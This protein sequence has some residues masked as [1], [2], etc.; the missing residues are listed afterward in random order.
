[1]RSV[2]SIAISLCYVGGGRFDAMLTGRASRSVDAAAGQL[3]AREARRRGRL[4]R[5]GA[6]RELGPGRPIPRRRRPRL[7][8][9]RDGARGT[10]LR[11][12]SPRGRGL[13]VDRFVDWSLAQRVAI[14][15]AG[16]GSDPGYFSRP[17]VESAC[18]EAIGLVVEYTRL[19]PARPIPRP[20]VVDRAEWARVGLR[21]LS[22]VSARVRGAHRR[23]LECAGA[24]GGHRPVAGRRRCGSRGRSRRRLR[25]AEG[26][27][28]IRHRNRPIRSARAPAV[29]RA[30]PRRHAPPA[31]RDA[32]G[33][34]EV[35]RDPRDHARGAV[36]LCA[37][38][39][40]PP[41]GSPPGAHRRRRGADGPRVAPGPRQADADQRPAQDDQVAAAGRSREDARGARAGA[42]AGPPP[43]SDVR[44]RGARRARD[45][46]RRAPRP[47]PA[48]LGCATASTCDELAGAASA[49][50]SRGSWAWS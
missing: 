44:H 24:A 26:P 41:C 29:R 48:T 11:R 42:G 35:D 45:G 28:S 14:G 33:V 30:E 31:R 46:H 18:D 12:A 7:R 16:G 15:V 49:R 4:R 50:S 13:T 6:R 23:R 2:G 20:E 47:S 43:G 32:G 40:W 34:P 36:H 8:D 19:T 22:E 3:V 10:A 39:P 9:A 37:V 5:R 17:A 21:T 27:R 38:A 1:M 25:S